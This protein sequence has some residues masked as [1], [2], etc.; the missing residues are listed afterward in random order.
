MRHKV[1][2]YA[3]MMTMLVL[4]ALVTSAYATRIF[5]GA[6]CQLQNASQVAATPK[7]GK[8]GTIENSSGITLNVVCP[9]VR[10][11]T[12]NVNGTQN[13]TVRVVSNGLDDVLCTSYST[14]ENG[15]LIDN[16]TDTT[17]SN[18]PETLNINLSLS[19]AKGTY[20]MGCELPPGSKIFNYRVHEY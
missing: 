15:N 1:F 13:F 4:T 8:E 16:F 10:D 11:N 6:E 20:S 9:V 2:I 7:Y 5:A 19:A 3:A 14:D 12:S 18:V 17:N